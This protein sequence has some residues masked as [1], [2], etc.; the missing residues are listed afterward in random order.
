MNI[1]TKR[2]VMNN[3]AKST[4]GGLTKKDIMTIERNGEKRYVSKKKSKLAVK[5]FSRWNDA[6]EQA[7]M[8]L[9]IPKNEFVLL[10]KS[11]KLYKRAAEIYY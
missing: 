9:G 1:G 10:K 8:E 4:S 5:N 2:Q 6:V 3:T 7:K 11:S